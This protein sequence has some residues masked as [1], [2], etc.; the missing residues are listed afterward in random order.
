MNLQLLGREYGFSETFLLPNAPYEDW[1]RHHKG[2]AFHSNTDALTDDPIGTYPW[3][4]ACMICVRAYEP[5]EDPDIVDAYY[6]ASNSAYHAM[7]QLLD[8]LKQE[9]IRVERADTPFRTQLLQAG[10]GSCMDNRLWYYPPYGTYVHL[11]GAML[12][13]PEPVEYSRPQHN[14][15]ICDHCSL[16]EKACFGALHEGSF[17]WKKCIRAYMENLPMPEEFLPKQNAFLGCSRCQ[18]A[19]PKNPLKRIP[20]PD[21]VR[22]AFDPLRII[23]GEYSEAIQLAGKNMKNNLIRQAIILC[24]NNNLTETLPH[25]LKLKE[26][27]GEKYAKELQYA[28]L[29]LQNKK[30]VIK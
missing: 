30:N 21:H 4:N 24:A 19:C 8:R 29:C 12:Q 3:A 9:G 16:C 7:K 20:V 15:Q 26:T 14:E 17:D 2:G 22:K 6:L 5:F 28:I 18:R 13:L 10:I 11:E 27:S 1:A 23:Q 25:L